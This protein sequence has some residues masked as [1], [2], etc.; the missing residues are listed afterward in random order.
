MYTFYV[1]ETPGKRLRAGVMIILKSALRRLGVRLY[2]GLIWP[3]RIRWWSFGLHKILRTSWVNEQLFSY[4]RTSND[5][6]SMLEP[7]ALLPMHSE[8]Y[9]LIKIEYTLLSFQFIHS[10]THSF[11][12]S[13]C[14]HQWFQWPSSAP[15]WST[16]NSDTYLELQASI[17]VFLSRSIDILLSILY[18][19]GVLLL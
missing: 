5:F 2:C 1:K 12:Q 9:V 11:I 6:Q 3:L 18:P 15:Q 13:L 16:R 19:R 7:S 4:S 17:I 8:L 14:K 10:F